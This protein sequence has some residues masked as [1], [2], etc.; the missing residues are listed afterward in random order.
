MNIETQIQEAINKTPIND[1]DVIK[2]Y[3]DA[4][5]NYN[6]LVKCGLIKPK[7]YSLATI[8]DNHVCMEANNMWSYDTF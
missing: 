1:K 5:R 6:K 3:E 4:I 2:S 8:E 7:G